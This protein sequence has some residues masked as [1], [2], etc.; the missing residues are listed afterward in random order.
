MKKFINYSLFFFFQ[1][2][3]FS[4]HIIFLP[5]YC[6]YLGYD[7]QEIA[8]FAVA[9][10]FGSIA[11]PLVITHLAHSYFSPQKIAL[12][13]WI[14]GLISYS[15]MFF[16]QDTFIF[17]LLFGISFF[18]FIGVWVLLEAH[19]VEEENYGGT[20]FEK[21]RLY[22]SI[23]FIVLSQLIA[24]FV[25][26]YGKPLI[27]FAGML[28]NISIVF[29]GLR[30]RS[31][32]PKHPEKLKESKEP[33]GKSKTRLF[34]KNYILMILLTL[35]IWASHGVFYVY[36]SIYLK[37]L[38][39][40]AAEISF[41][42][43]L[44]VISEIILFMNFSKLEKRFSI[45]S[46]LRFSCLITILRWL[47]L[48]FCKIKYLLIVSNL[49]HAFTFGAFYLGSRKFVTK[50]LPTNLNAKGQ[51]ILSGI[52]S[53]SGSFLG[54]VLCMYTV[55]EISSDLELNELFIGSSYL[56][57]LALAVSYLIKDKKSY[58]NKLQPEILISAKI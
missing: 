41:S 57:T 7:P 58:S 46:I 13:A 22:G 19:L 1:I 24:F 56:A 33:L 37:A 14:F 5:L 38:G 12:F 52:G 48:A 43:N 39:F 42:W 51:G 36:L 21:V 10:T 49:L 54:R 3:S 23:G 34:Q 47:I 45:I 31:Y 6:K 35:L 44:G 29:F 40:S 27:L 25:D 26:L 30:I 18:C 50:I 17:S 8:I 53:G 11:G 16:L 9:A 20:P 32:L 4:F 55:G 2:G 15:L 28:V